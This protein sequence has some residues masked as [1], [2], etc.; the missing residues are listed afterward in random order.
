MNLLASQKA[1]QTAALE[2]FALPGDPAFPLNA[3]YQPPRDRV[4]AEAL[5]GYISQMRQELVTRLLNRVY[6]DGGAKPSKV[7]S[8]ILP[9]SNSSETRCADNELIVV[10]KLHQETFYGQ[11]SVNTQ[12]T[13]VGVIKNLFIWVNWACAGQDAVCHFSQSKGQPNIIPYTKA[14]SA[15]SGHQKCL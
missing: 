11:E 8:Y 10:A 7:L 3:L 15:P 1:L 9:L 6:A 13:V 2:Q 12:Y 5:R 4:E 14:Q